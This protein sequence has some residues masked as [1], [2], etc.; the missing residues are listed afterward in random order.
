MLPAA[1]RNSRQF[2]PH[3]TNATSK[4]TKTATYHL[5]R[6]V[7]SLNH[8]HSFSS[9]PLF[10]VV[11]S[12]DGARRCSAPSSIYAQ[13]KCFHSSEIESAV[14]HNSKCQHP[15][16]AAG[17]NTQNQSRLSS[18]SSQFIYSH[19]TYLN[20]RMVCPFFSLFSLFLSSLLVQTPIVR[21]NAAASFACRR[22]TSASL[23]HTW[24]N[25]TICQYWK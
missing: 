18:N 13:S 8:F 6:Q 2:R 1:R 3:P 25:L 16:P 23:I 11:I 22:S 4:P 14:R 9:I 15:P 20:S 17:K 10:N 7:P 24:F 19:R 21:R 5:T 12:I